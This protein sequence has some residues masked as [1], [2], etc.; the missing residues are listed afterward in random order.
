LRLCG[1]VGRSSYRSGMELTF[2][3]EIIHWRGPSPFHF[4]AVPEVQR[5]AIEAVAREVTYG[6]GCIPVSGRVGETDFTTS[7]IPKDGGYLVP[8]KVAV[9]R[10]EDL[11][12]GDMVNVRLMLAV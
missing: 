7:L 5:G 3:G 9:R 11:E 8:L 4:V 12:L 10:A 6:W 2:S 1:W